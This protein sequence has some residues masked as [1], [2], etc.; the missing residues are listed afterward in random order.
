MF[1]YSCQVRY[2]NYLEI[3]LTIWNTVVY[4]FVLILLRLR[5]GAYGFHG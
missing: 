3:C 1:Y 5:M 4:V 2:M